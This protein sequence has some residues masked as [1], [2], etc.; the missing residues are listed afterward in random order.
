MTEDLNVKMRTLGQTGIKISPIGLGTNKFSGG[1]GLYGLVM[2]DLSQEDINEIVNSALE[3]G[4]N[5]FDTAEMYGIFFP[6]SRNGGHGRASES[7]E[8][9]FRWR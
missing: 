9:S 3:G 1:K 8:N 6:G 7:R 2:P 4:I 5:W